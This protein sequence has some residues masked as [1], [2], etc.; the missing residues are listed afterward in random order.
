MQEALT[1][2]RLCG[3]RIVEIQA[4]R[5]SSRRAFPLPHGNG[6]KL[7]QHPKVGKLRT[8]KDRDRMKAYGAGLWASFIEIDEPEHQR[9]CPASGCP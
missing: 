8:A 7:A 2:S 3:E 5:L 4:A 1:Q 6:L 9:R